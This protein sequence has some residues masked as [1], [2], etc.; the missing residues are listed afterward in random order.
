MSLWMVG[1]FQLGLARCHHSYLTDGQ[2]RYFLHDYEPSTSSS[3][4]P[5]NHVTHAHDVLFM[6]TVH[7]YNKAIRLSSI[8]ISWEGNSPAECLHTWACFVDAASQ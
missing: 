1:G 3:R 7:Q 2:V 6:D 4:P 5:S 8:A